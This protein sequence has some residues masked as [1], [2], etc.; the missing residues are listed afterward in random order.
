MWHFCMSL[1]QGPV[2]DAANFAARYDSLCLSSQSVPLFISRQLMLFLDRRLQL[3]F[4]PLQSSRRAMKIFDRVQMTV[5]WAF[6]NC[7]RLAS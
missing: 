3:A 4:P 7:L 5:E 1:C 2:V 6:G